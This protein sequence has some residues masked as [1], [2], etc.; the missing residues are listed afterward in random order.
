MR[1]TQGE[2]TVQRLIRER[3]LQQVAGAEAD[4]TLWVA[5]AARTVKAAQTV[6]QVD[7]DSAYVLAYDAARQACTALLV[8]QGLW[9]IKDNVPPP[10]ADTTSSRKSSGH[11]SATF[12]AA[13]ARSVDDATNWNT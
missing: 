7:P 2:A 13:L 3:R 6:A 4:G 1:W 10:T 9:F 12:C 11:S 8:H 5:R